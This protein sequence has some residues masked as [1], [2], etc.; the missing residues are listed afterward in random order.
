MG[1]EL[2]IQAMTLD[3]L[4]LTCPECGTGS[5]TLDGRGPID[6]LASVW[7]N[8][9]NYHSW[10]HQLLTID[11]LRAIDAARTGRRRAEDDD[12]FEIEIGGA[13]LAGILAPELTTDDLRKAGRIYWRRIIKPAVR[14]RKNAAK[15]AITQPIKTGARN[16]VAAAKA[17]ALEAAWTV[18][19]GG[20]QLDPDYVPE[21]V[22][23]CPACKGRGHHAIKSRIHETTSVRCSV[24]TGTG[25]ID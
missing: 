23:P 4:P 13:C 14:R 11:D 5:F 16:T 9:A 7:A 25:E 2:K 10:E 19:A 18:Q 12:T 24:C 15:R 3:G 17:A 6:V 22:N 21:P 1:V 20:Y 8:C